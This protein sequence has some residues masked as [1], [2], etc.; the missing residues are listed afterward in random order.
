MR[1]K[2]CC[3]SSAQEVSI[4]LDAGADILGFVA[5][6]LGGLGV[7]PEPLI[8]ALI[9]QVP[10][11]VTAM[12]LTGHTDLDRL[13]PQIAAARPAA[14]QLVKP[15]TP[16]VR[17]AL[18]A[19]F[20]CLRIAQVV[21]VGGVDAVAAAVAAQEESDAVLLDSSAPGKLG[22]TGATHDWSISARVVRACDVPVFLAG[23]LNADNIAVA[24]AT[25]R[26]AGV[27]LCTGVRTN[28]QLDPH[29]TAAFVAAAKAAR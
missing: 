4:A 18:R 3:I 20:P 10:L 8:A 29:L 16:A 28:D 13:V 2:V 26:P 21:H 6:P 12:L 9:A 25:V 1:V 14:V 5:P 15:T 19:R 7:I 24:I 27:D 11:S 22:A 23:G 17:A